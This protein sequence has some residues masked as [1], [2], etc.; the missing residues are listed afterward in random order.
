MFVRR[1][2]AFLLVCILLLLTSCS[3]WTVE[4]YVKEKK[5]HYSYIDIVERLT[6]TEWMAMD[7]AKDETE[8]TYQ[9]ST[10][11]GESKYN[12]NKD[13]Y[14]GWDNNNDGGKRIRDDDGGSVLLDVKGAGYVSRMWFVP[15]YQGGVVHIEVDGKTV[16]HMD[17]LEFLLGVNSTEIA[18]IDD[19]KASVSSSYYSNHQ[20]DM[21]GYISSNG[22]NY[23]VPISFNESCKIVFY[24]KRAGT[25]NDVSL[26][27]QIDYTLFPEGITAEPFVG[28]DNMSKANQKALENANKQ[29]RA[30]VFKA[31]N[32]GKQY[33]LSG[34]KSVEIYKKDIS[35]AIK[36]LQLSLDDLSDAERARAL[37]DLSI[38][39][40]WDGSDIPSVSVSL[41]DFFG[42]P[43]AYAP[44]QTYA[45]GALENGVMYNLFYMPFSKAKAVVTNNSTD[46][47]YTFKVSV[48]DEVIADGKAQDTLR[49]CANAKRLSDNDVGNDRWP[50]STSFEAVGH[51]RIVGQLW[52]TYQVFDGYWWG[53]GDER[54][55]VDGE[56]EPSWYGTGG[57]DIIG[58]ASAIPSG[59]IFSAPFRAHS[60]GG[61]DVFLKGNRLNTWLLGAAA[62]TYDECI[63]MSLEKYW[64]DDFSRIYAVT[65]H[66]LH[67]DDL[68]KNEFGTFDYT[69]RNE[70]FPLDD[71]ESDIP[72]LYRYEGEFL[73]S[74]A[75]VSKGSLQNI[76]YKNASRLGY[77]LW[78]N[79]D[80]ADAQ[81][82][83]PFTVAEDGIYTIKMTTLTNTNLGIF[84]IA[85]DGKAL[86]ENV[87]MYGSTTKQMVL[88][89]GPQSLKKG[90]HVF[91]ITPTGVNPSGKGSYFCAIDSIDVIP[92]GKIRIESGELRLMTVTK[93]GGDFLWQN[94]DQSS[95]SGGEHFVWLN[96][97]RKGELSFK[98]T[99]PEEGIYDI[100]FSAVKSMNYSRIELLIDGNVI[101][102]KVDLFGQG[103]KGTGP[104]QMG[105]TKLSAGNH[106]ITFKVVG[107]NAKS[108]GYYVPFDYLEF[109]LK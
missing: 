36:S 102:D 104:V 78:S 13:E 76:T 17:I 92:Q 37:R 75:K 96:N 84:T 7:F 21:L 63:E 56:K 29:L 59:A 99:L 44:Y 53:E 103:Y 50:D 41:G 42:T 90:N 64:D 85:L 81:L 49:F 70:G 15:I 88:D 106:T 58:Y 2:L 51:G 67:P 61:E 18:N 87:D 48:T 1:G 108:L 60:Y 30:D 66:Y 68:V 107:K 52:H 5:T 55:F 62:V 46:A 26:Y 35:G 97:N 69:A 77:L 22:Y 100:V 89:F 43:G 54:M 83:L 91:T 40:Y 24:N 71:E 72:S 28:F 45:M 101:G 8:K 27:K 93:T 80:K 82:E 95:F 20:Y 65:Y 33:T 6:S 79:K 23:F 73:R 109:V 86:L 25:D 32:G 10:G 57:E 3:G 4:P 34:E 74:L 47:K 9:W 38:D 12:A 98:V 31:K 19:W 11:S 14:I 94:S 105:S 39:M 16:V